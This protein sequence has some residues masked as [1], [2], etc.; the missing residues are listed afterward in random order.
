M[1]QILPEGS[2]GLGF[3]ALGGFWDL[4]LRSLLISWPFCRVGI[5]GPRFGFGGSLQCLRLL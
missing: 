3:R 1:V 2:D 4:G 5:L